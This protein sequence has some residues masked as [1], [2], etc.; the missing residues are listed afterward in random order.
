MTGPST[1]A[2]QLSVICTQLASQHTCV[3]ALSYNKRN[4]T[5]KHNK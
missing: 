1:I 5:W 3:T 2:V 4:E